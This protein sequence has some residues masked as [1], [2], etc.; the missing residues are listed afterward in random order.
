MYDARLLNCALWWRLYLSSLVAMVIIHLLLL[1]RVNELSFH[2]SPRFSVELS[3]CCGENLLKSC[4][5]ACCIINHSVLLQVNCMWACLLSFLQLI[6][7]DFK[8]KIQ[9]LIK[10]NKH[11]GYADSLNCTS[12]SHKI[13]FPMNT[14][15]LKT[16]H[17]KKQNMVA[18]FTEKQPLSLNQTLYIII[19]KKIP[20]CISKHE[21]V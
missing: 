15:S 20:C 8:Q 6:C 3:A 21:R 9:N 14:T 12:G 2:L 7:E 5:I 16:T 10:I 17:L 1:G 13:W 11:H 4:I 19:F 18:L